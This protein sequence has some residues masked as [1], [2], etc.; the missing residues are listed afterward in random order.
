MSTLIAGIAVLVSACGTSQATSDQPKSGGTLTFRLDAD[1]QTMNPFEGASS[2]VST[3]R[4]IQ[5]LWPNLYDADKNL[6]IVP[7]LADGTMFRFLSAS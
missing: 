1:A 7:G 4:A 6:N 2:D 5:W 3:A